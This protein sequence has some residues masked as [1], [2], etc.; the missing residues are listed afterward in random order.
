[1]L[2]DLVRQPLLEVEILPPTCK[3]GEVNHE[4]E[5]LA[6]QHQR[7]RLEVLRD[8]EDPGESRVLAVSLL[9][10]LVVPISHTQHQDWLDLDALAVPGVREDYPRVGVRGEENLEQLAKQLLS[11]EG[12]GWVDLKQ[13]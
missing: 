4:R 2:P 5:R 11:Q 1:M 9:G 12:D 10:C 6:V 8:V 3:D 7:E 13:A